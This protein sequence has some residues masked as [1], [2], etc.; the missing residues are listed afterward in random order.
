VFTCQ[1]KQYI[2][3]NQMAIASNFDRSVWTNLLCS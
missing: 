2:E 1:L 3:T